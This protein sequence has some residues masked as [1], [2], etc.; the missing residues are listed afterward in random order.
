[1]NDSQE[2]A[3]NIE[4]W[5]VK[6]LIQ[7][8][9]K[10]RGLGTSLI[11]LII[12]PTEQLSF[13]SRMVNDEC[14]S[15]TS[16]KSRN[17]RQSTLSA[18]TSI[19]ERLKLYGNKMPKNGLAIFCGE[20]LNEKDIIE[21]KVTIDIQPFRPINTK[22]YI[23]D[24]KFHTEALKD[25]LVMEEKYGFIIIDGNGT[26]FGTLQG[27][28]KD[29]LNQFSVD[30]PKKYRKGGQS[31]TRYARLRLEA[32]YN[33]LKKIAEQAAV[34]FITNEKINVAGLV[35]GVSAD[36]KK[37]LSESELF[38]ERLQSKIVKIVDIAY[39]GQNGFEQAIELSAVTLNN[40]KFIREKTVLTK[41]FEE[42]T[43]DTKK[44]CYG[45][46]NTMKALMMGAC[47]KVILYENL[48]II[49][50]MLRNS[51]TGAEEVEYCDREDEISTVN[52][53]GEKLEVAEQGTLS[54][55]LVDN[56]IMY[57]TELELVTDNSQEG[58]QFSRAFE[59]IGA[60]LRYQL[61]ESEGESEEEEEWDENAV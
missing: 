59:G 58:S 18:L 36:F 53:D 14:N 50:T 16:I 34:Q 43:Q 33:Y 30:L 61:D 41:F 49:R 20:I 39:G 11:T 26:L 47:E 9:D 55:W 4:Q 42:I 15:A 45:V 2:L 60:F 28:T 6:R 19:R 23:C 31:S 46:E 24:N 22:I 48:S 54:E 25:L 21:K 5:K 32:R 8:L 29:I 10:C 3:D 44:F 1:M 17:M 35:L 57:G 37:D 13:A 52:E 56:Y 38:D 27:N 12:P 40:A 7:S 51:E